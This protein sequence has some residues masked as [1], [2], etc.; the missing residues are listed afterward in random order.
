MD[1]SEVGEELGEKV[2]FDGNID[3][4]YQELILE[5]MTTMEYL[6]RRDFYGRL[7]NYTRA[8][9]G[10]SVDNYGDITICDKDDGVISEHSSETGKGCASGNGQYSHGTGIEFED[11]LMEL[12]EPTEGSLFTL[13][14]D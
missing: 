4:V 14:N 6:I 2:V 12:E 1:L 7:G 13:C 9:R 11:Y 10:I 8:P 3:H 5:G